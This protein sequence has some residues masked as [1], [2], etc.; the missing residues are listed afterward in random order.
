MDVGLSD[1]AKAAQL[2]SCRA[3]ALFLLW[4]GHKAPFS[5]L[6]CSLTAVFVSLHCLRQGAEL[7]LLTAAKAAY[8]FAKAKPPL[9]GGAELKLLW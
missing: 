8:V 3:K 6:C 5:T 7:K 1:A 4:R 2:N 9:R